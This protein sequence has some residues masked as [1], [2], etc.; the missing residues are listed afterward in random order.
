MLPSVTADERVILRAALADAKQRLE[1][2]LR[3]GDAKLR[4]VEA[5]GERRPDWEELW[6]RLLASYIAVCDAQAE[7]DADRLPGSAHA[8]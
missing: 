1:Q 8:A 2:R 6:L 3:R 5:R 4:A 7:L